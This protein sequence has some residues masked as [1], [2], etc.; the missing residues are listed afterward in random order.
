MRLNARLSVLV[1]SPLLTSH[2]VSFSRNKGQQSDV[3]RERP[4]KNTYLTGSSILR[5][6]TLMLMSRKRTRKRLR[7]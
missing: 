6:M 1:I 7:K 3:P 2:P 4:K 5:T